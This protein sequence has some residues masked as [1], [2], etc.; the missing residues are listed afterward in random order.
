MT[1][2]LTVLLAVTLLSGC[3]FLK[4]GQYGA[5][6][7]R[8]TGSE[9]Q[10]YCAG[11]DV[12]QCEILVRALEQATDLSE[13]ELVA[14][15]DLVAWTCS[16]GS[17]EACLILGIGYVFGDRPDPNPKKSHKAL[18]RGC[19]VSEFAQEATGFGCFYAGSALAEGRLGKVDEEGALPLFERAC[20]ARHP[21]AC[22][23]AGLMHHFG[24]G[25]EVD[26]GRAQFYFAAGC[27][28]GEDMVGCFNRA[29]YLYEQP[30]WEKDVERIRGYFERAC[31]AD[32]Q[33]AC[34]NLLLLPPP[35]Q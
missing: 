4:W 9:A 35:E 31:R 21:E 8:Y 25:T 12:E 28:L 30:G 23:W 17:D 3:V 5:M 15:G 24:K 32:N 2:T 22:S 20:V 10:A 18:E 1:R 26:F 7:D 14:Q 11:G 19:H 6:L 16:L 33:H 29:M 13:E 34:D 27:D